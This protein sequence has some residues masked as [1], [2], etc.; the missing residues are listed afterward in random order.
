M[1]DIK[2]KKILYQLDLNSRQN[3]NQIAKKVKLSKDIVNYRIKK[4][5]KENYILGYQTIINFQKIGYLTIRTRITLIDTSPKKEKEIIDFFV[6]EKKV[7]FVLE[8]EG[9]ELTFGLMIEN[10]FELK[11]FYEKFETSFKKF[12]QNKRFAIYLE[13]YHFNRSY[14]LKTKEK[15]TIILKENKKEKLDKIDLK[16]LKILAKNARASTLDIA[17]KLKIPATTTAHRIKKLQEKKIIL[18]YRLLFNFNKIQYSYF[19]V[20]LELKDISNIKKL[21]NY[22]EINKNIIYAMKTLGGS[23]LEIYFESTQE[24][25]LKSMKKMRNLFPEIRKWDYDILKRYHK[26]NYFLD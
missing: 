23:D 6:K 15:N 12:I 7:F 19:R 26:F 9:T 11:Q 13:L 3:F 4:L 25:F 24:E 17:I 5:E 14:L 2:D 18:G 16:I 1:L 8:L 10:L 21:M 22:G 20:N